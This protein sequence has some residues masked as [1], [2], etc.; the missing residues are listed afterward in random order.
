MEIKKKKIVLLVDGVSDWLQ[1]WTAASSLDMK[2]NKAIKKTFFV[3]LTDWCFT[4]RL[5][6]HNYSS[7]YLVKF[8]KSMQ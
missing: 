8:L 2:G 6:C 1:I 5:V 3:S 7:E 4:N